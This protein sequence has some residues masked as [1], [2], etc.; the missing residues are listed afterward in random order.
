MWV[1]TPWDYSSPSCFTLSPQEIPFPLGR[2]LS[3][4][5]SSTHTEPSSYFKLLVTNVICKRKG[6][7]SPSS[8]LGP[9]CLLPI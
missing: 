3:A 2:P 4:P 7:N 6:N 8:P 1:S 9:L 5:P